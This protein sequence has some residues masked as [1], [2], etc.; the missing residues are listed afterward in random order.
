MALPRM[1]RGGR[2]ARPQFPLPYAALAIYYHVAASV[3]MDPRE[4]VARGR[5]TARKALELDPSMPEAHAWLGIFAIVYDLNWKEGGRR[6]N[7]HLWEKRVGGV[8]DCGACPVCGHDAVC[9]PV[10]GGYSVVSHVPSELSAIG[11]P[12]RPLWMWLGR[13]YAVLMIAFGWIVWRSAPPNRALR[14]VGALLMA[15]TVFGQFWPPMHQRAVL[16]AGGGTLTDT[17]HLVWAMVT[18]V[19]FMFMVGFGAA[20]LGKRF[21]FYSIATMGSSSRAARYRN[22]ASRIQAN[23]PRQ[24]SASGSAQHRH[25]HGVDRGMATALRGPTRRRLPT[26]GPAGHDHERLRISESPELS[27]RL[28]RA[29]LRPVSVMAEEER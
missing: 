27:A 18:G 1:L 24:G 7:W 19:V 21:R 26:S 15:H 29:D 3:V 13:V 5:G 11:A 4:A 10:V 16:A 6:F 22:Y 23:C 20:A 12:T 28:C 17:L 9:R 14:V 25:V 8:W 2:Q